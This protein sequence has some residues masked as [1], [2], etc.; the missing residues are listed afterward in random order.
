MTVKKKAHKPSPLERYLALINARLVA[1]GALIDSRSEV[2]TLGSSAFR[3]EM[4]ERLRVIEK[5]IDTI[6]RHIGVLVSRV[7]DVRDAPVLTPEDTH[8]DNC[9]H[10]Y[11]W[12]IVGDRWTC[13]K[14]GKTVPKST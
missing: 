14:C 8:M 4:G 13:V 6:Q 2:H 7:K 9:L 3:A 10:K 12:A 5:D 11:E 1:L